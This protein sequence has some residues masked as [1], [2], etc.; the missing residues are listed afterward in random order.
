[1]GKVSK[2]AFTLVAS[3]FTADKQNGWGRTL[4]G[5]GGLDSARRLGIAG[6]MVNVRIVNGKAQAQAKGTFT[7]AGPCTVAK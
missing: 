2:D 4:T 3:V 7:L 5:K 1:M 6:D